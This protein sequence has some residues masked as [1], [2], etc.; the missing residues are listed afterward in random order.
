MRTGPKLVTIAKTYADLPNE[1]LAVMVDSEGKIIAKFLDGK[2]D[3][4]DDQTEE[5]TLT[6]VA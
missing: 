3:S 4:Y 5:P 6:P 2:L 1:G